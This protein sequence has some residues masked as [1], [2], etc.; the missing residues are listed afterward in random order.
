MT[1]KIPDF[2]LLDSTISFLCGKMELKVLR[3]GQQPKIPDVPFLFLD[4]PAELRSIIYHILFNGAVRGVEHGFLKLS[5]CKASSGLILRTCRL[6]YRETAPILF[7]QS[8]VRYTRQFEVYSPHDLPLAQKHAIRQVEISNFVHHSTTLSHHRLR[9]YHNLQVLRIEMFHLIIR[10]NQIENP[11]VIY[12]LPGIRDEFLVA[13]TKAAIQSDSSNLKGP[14]GSNLL[15]KYIGD[16][17]RTENIEVGVSI[18]L[19]HPK[20][21]DILLVS[22]I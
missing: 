17:R 20:S 1:T 6:I 10:S 15:W 9:G 7:S 8:T 13:Q 14:I 22:R 16:K 21:S 4:L 3:P 5:T 2:R 18:S 12:Q 19:K 11:E